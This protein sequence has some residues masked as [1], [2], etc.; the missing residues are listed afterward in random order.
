MSIAVT[1]DVPEGLETP[2]GQ[3]YDVGGDPV[4]H[5][6]GGDRPQEEDGLRL[7][8]ALFSGGN[9]SLV[10]THY[11]ME[12]RLTDAVL[13]L[14]TNTGLAE[15]T[16]HVIDVCREFGWP[17]LIYPAP[18]SLVEF[19]MKY[20]FPGSAFHSVAYAYF[21]KRQLEYL[22]A[23]FD[24]KPHYYTG[25]YKGESDRRA[26]T[27]SDEEVDEVRQWF[28][29]APFHDY[30]GTEFDHYRESHDLPVNPVA[31]K[32]HRSGDC[33]CGAFAHRDELLVD[34]YA[35][36][37]DRHG[38][39]LLE[40]EEAVQ[41]YRRKLALF[42]DRHPER[43]A[44]VDQWR[45]GLSPKPMR[46]PVFRFFFPFEA[47]WFDELPVYVPQKRAQSE[48]TNYWGHGEMSNKELTALLAEI[49]DSQ[50]ELCDFYEN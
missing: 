44:W 17:L 38:D 25:V 22:A 39:W 41:I 35:K 20:G 9:D 26:T 3:P 13:Y 27:V 8:Y 46:M 33:Y 1:P 45:K 34:L 50:F 2:P 6:F 42:K 15:N 31:A 30:D 12:N 23:K 47:S 29:H 28:W 37:Y 36:G 11:C 32:I 18:M 19:A 48:P 40:V 7:S 5:D 14:C 49:D 43:Y 24:G 4:W 21:K 16:E 10:T